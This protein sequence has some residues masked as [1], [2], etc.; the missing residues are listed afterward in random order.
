LKLYGKDFV[1][2]DPRLSGQAE[3]D[4]LLWWFLWAWERFPR[5]AQLRSVRTCSNLFLDMLNA[6]WLYTGKVTGVLSRAALGRLWLSQCPPS[7]EGRAWQ[8]AAR[9]GFWGDHG[10]LLPWLYAENLKLSETLTRQTGPLLE[11]TS[12]GRDLQTQVPFSFSPRHYLLVDPSRHHDVRDAFAA[13]QRDPGMFLTSENALKLYLQHRNPWEYTVLRK[14]NRD[15]A[16]APPSNVSW[17]R[18]VSVALH[19]EIPRGAGFSARWTADH[20]R[21]I[22]LR[23]AQCRLYA[24]HGVVALGPEDLVRRYE[25][26]HGRWPYTGQPS[27]DDYCLR[28]Y[29]ITCTTIDA[30]KSSFRVR[31]TM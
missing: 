3:R 24:D 1:R 20:G 10:F 30:L 16:M 11:G 5:F 4:S 22:G 9:R 29:P 25:L 7:E 8:R 19:R 17:Q 6:Y 2:P 23:Y 13:M 26:H 15:F 14:Q 21:A 27:R 18:A 31:R 28:D 12:G